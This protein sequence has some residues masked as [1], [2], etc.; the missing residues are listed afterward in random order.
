MHN[1]S[2][3]SVCISHPK[4]IYFANESLKIADKMGNHF[5]VSLFYLN[6]QEAS[7]LNTF[8]N[9]T[10]DNNNVL[11]SFP[12]EQEI[13]A[14]QL[15]FP[16]FSE[17]NSIESSG[18]FVKN[19]KFNALTRKYLNI[20][21]EQIEQSQEKENWQVL[22][23]AKRNL[24]ESKPHEYLDSIARDICKEIL[25]TTNV[26]KSIQYLGIVGSLVELLEHETDKIPNDIDIMLC[27]DTISVEKYKSIEDIVKNVLNAYS[28]DELTFYPLFSATPSKTEFSLD[29]NEFPVQVLI[30]NR[31]TISQLSPFVASQR[32]KT[33]I[34]YKGKIED[35]IIMQTFSMNDVIEKTFGIDSSIKSISKE[36]YFIFGESW[37]IDGDSITYKENYE[38]IINNKNKMSF[39]KYSIKWNTI[40]LFEATDTIIPKGIS[41]MEEK[42]NWIFFQAKVQAETKELVKNVI[43]NNNLNA[44]DINQVETCTKDYLNN[45]KELIQHT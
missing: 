13:N 29:S 24:W 6:G 41:S 28:H 20:L 44:Y 30:Y 19:K 15:T 17:N 3:T 36:P 5:K 11:I 14:R 1:L 25:K 7:P 2:E 16:L 45:L 35:F 33:H 40:N 8:P 42:L 10:L 9:F 4:E 39:C 22:E 31:K 43:L 27:I 34:S 21:T 23:V 26:E 32:L 37:I 12:L 38:K 18:I